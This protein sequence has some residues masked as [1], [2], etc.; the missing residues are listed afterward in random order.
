MGGGG[1]I[2]RVGGVALSPGCGLV[3]FYRLPFL[4]VLNEREKSFIFSSFLFIL[5]RFVRQ[6]LV[7]WL[8]VLYS[9]PDSQVEQTSFF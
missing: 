7:S 2:K 4:I 9:V 3:G 6:F 5:F 1:G 8:T